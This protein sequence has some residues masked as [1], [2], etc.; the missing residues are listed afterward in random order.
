ML[1][2]LLCNLLQSLKAIIVVLMSKSSIY[3]HVLDNHEL[4]L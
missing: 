1:L 3:C 4:A 2:G